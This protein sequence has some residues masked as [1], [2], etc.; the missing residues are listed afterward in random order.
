M[1][2][3]SQSSYQAKSVTNIAASQQA[4]QTQQTQQL[5]ANTDRAQAAQHQDNQVQSP[6]PGENQPIPGSV[7]GSRIN[8]TA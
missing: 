3:S 8:T 1:E 5:K 7:V 2:I 6:K 4:Q